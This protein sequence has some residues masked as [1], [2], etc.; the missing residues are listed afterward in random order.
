M[1]T[2]TLQFESIMIDEDFAIT[3]K[4]DHE[5]LIETNY[6][7]SPMGQKGVIYLSCNAGAARLLVPNHHADT[8][9]N[10]IKT[11]E[12]A[13][14]TSGK[15][16]GKPAIEILFEDHTDTP[17]SLHILEQACDRHFAD[18]AN[19]T[20]KLL[21]YI[22]NG[23]VSNEETKPLELTPPLFVPILVSTYAAKHR[24]ADLPCL[25]PWSIGIQHAI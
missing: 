21:I 18:R 6:F 15:L 12:Y 4:N 9:V 2:N 1:D 8:V 7:D 22:S 3:T 5:F 16:A 20:F 24:Y 14:I 25:Q 23:L 11:A 10:E 19:K 17:F 13:I